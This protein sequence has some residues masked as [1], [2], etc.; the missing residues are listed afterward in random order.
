MLPKTVLVYARNCRKNTPVPM[1]PVF[2]D[3]TESVFWFPMKY[4]QHKDIV[5]IRIPSIKIRRPR[6]CY[7]Y[8]GNLHTRRGHLYIKGGPDCAAHVGSKRKTILISLISIISLEKGSIWAFALSP[9]QQ[10]CIYNASVTTRRTCYG[11]CVSGAAAKLR[12]KFCVSCGCL[13][14][15]WFCSHRTG[16]AHLLRPPCLRR[17]DSHAE[18]PTA[19][20][21]STYWRRAFAEPSTCVRRATGHVSVRRCACLY[22][23]GTVPHLRRTLP[24]RF[25]RPTNA[26]LMPAG[27]V[28]DEIN[29]DFFT[30]WTKRVGQLRWLACSSTSLWLRVLITSHVLL[31]APF[32][33]HFSCWQKH[34]LLLSYFGLRTFCWSWWAD[35]FPPRLF[36]A[37]YPSF[38]VPS[39]RWADDNAWD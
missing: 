6:S 16:N 28:S 18:N 27:M 7:C 4:C 21:H 26:N 33:S 37:P 35:H 24:V 25:G 22:L 20:A 14:L 38:W 8:N 29:Q 39:P 2:Y 11:S 9:F 31:S 10:W 32:I 1:V 34:F 19:K 17:T 5:T 15:K 3:Q 12:L 23:S 36:V 13:G 30:I